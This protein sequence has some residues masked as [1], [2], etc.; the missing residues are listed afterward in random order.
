MDDDE[1]LRLLDDYLEPPAEPNPEWAGVEI[2][3]EGNNNAFGSRHILETHRITEAEVEQ[4]LLEVPPVV[5]ARRHPA[6]PDRTIFWGATR[7]DRWLFILCEDWKEEEIG[8]AH[9]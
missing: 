4:V 3:W 7:L 8:R 5:E 2:I 1:L 9:V 6:Y